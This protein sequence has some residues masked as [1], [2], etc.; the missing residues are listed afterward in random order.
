MNLVEQF[1]HDVN[2]SDCLRYEKWSDYRTQIN[3]FFEPYFTK[4][5]QKES[6]LIL[7]AGNCDDLDLSFYKSHFSSITLAD[8][9]IKSTKQG[10]LRQKLSLN[11]CKLV[12]ADFTGHEKTSYFD[13]FIDDLA[14]LS[15]ISEIHAYLKEKM[16]S[17]MSHQFMETY[18]HHFDTIIISPVYTQLFYNQV[19]NAVLV[20][21]ELNVEQPLLDSILSQCLQDMISIIDHFNQNSLKLLK[22]NGSIFVL[23]DIFQSKIDE[24][25]YQEI[26]KSIHL[27][28]E[29]DK[30]HETYVDSY[31]YG[32]GD[33]GLYSMFNHF[34]DE[35][36]SWLLWPFSDQIH[37]C[38]KIVSFE[39][40]RK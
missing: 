1:N 24:P 39:N 34:T 32:L 7:G 33:Y 4:D 11:D 26:L 28:D 16:K 36:H 3:L 9:D 8:I 21:K 38:V 6:L 13:Q 35:I 20:L 40:A 37:L 29:M 14:M 23:S 10:L 30:L 27:T 31:G 5:K 2:S 22:P 12:Q 15:S 17:I 25:F 18:H 19:Q